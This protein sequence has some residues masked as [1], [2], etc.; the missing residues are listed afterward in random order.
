MYRSLQEPCLAYPEF[1][2]CNKVNLPGETPYPAR[3]NAVHGAPNR[4][5]TPKNDIIV[6]HIYPPWQRD[7]MEATYANAITSHG[8][9]RVAVQLHMLCLPSILLQ[10]VK[11]TWY[12]VSKKLLAS[13]EVNKCLPIARK[14]MHHALEISWCL[15][16]LLPTHWA[17]NFVFVGFARIKLVW[18]QQPSSL[19]QLSR[20]T[21]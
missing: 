17:S 13:Q 16:Q 11:I 3:R 18:T 1:Q 4:Q 5:S 7:N 20:L 6:P 15:D 8:P 14:G 9:F 10:V 12:S 21:H 19:L 2:P